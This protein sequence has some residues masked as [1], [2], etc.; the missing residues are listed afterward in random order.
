MF[1]YIISGETKRQKIFFL[2]G[3]SRSGKGTMLRIMSMLMGKLNVV[4]PTI[5]D[6]CGA[7]GRENVVDKSLLII[8]ELDHTDQRAVNAAAAIML[9]ISGED[10]LD[11][12]RKNK[13]QLGGV[14][15]VARI[16]FAGNGSPNFNQHTTAM[17]N[18]LLV[19]PFEVSFVGREDWD[20][21]EK[22]ATELP[23][24]LIWATEGLADLRAEDNFVEPSVS[25][26]AKAEVLNSGD[27]TRGFVADRCELDP[28]ATARKD[29]L[30]AEY[31]S[32]CKEAEARP[33]NRQ[34]FF[35]ALKTHFPTVR[36]AR[37]GSDGDRTQVYVGIGLR[38]EDPKF[39]MLPIR[40]DG[41]LLRIGFAPME[42][43]VRTGDGGL[44]PY[45]LSE[46]ADFGP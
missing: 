17:G 9:S 38:E 1:G 18:R 2:R 35:A 41:E 31:V 28:D 19:L 8:P 22:L 44:V 27:P 13:K 36:P 45:N 46:E 11:V 32:Y 34:K 40:V 37:L 20:L 14:R 25:V 12:N 43:I 16:I 6:L 30:F 21:T 4:S 42:A 7:F 29:D 23:G 24:I 5:Q 33:L 10:D 15:L 26:A 39:L 3:K